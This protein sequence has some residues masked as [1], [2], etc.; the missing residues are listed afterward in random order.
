M[1]DNWSGEKVV[2]VRLTPPC[3]WVSYVGAVTS[4]LQARGIKCDFT[5]VAGMSGYAFVVNVDPEL[6]PTGPVAFDWEM[7]IEGTQALGI[8]VEL[9]AVERNADDK[10]LEIELFERVRSEIDAG[11]CCVVWGAGEAPEFVIVYGYR[12]DSYLVRSSRSCRVWDEERALG[13]EEE[14][15]ESVRYDNLKAPWRLAAFFFGERIKPDVEL[16]ERQAIS[17]GVKLLRGQHACFDSGYFYGASAFRSWSDILERKHADPVGNA[18]NL[19]C[20][21]ELQM[22]AAG[23]CYRLA[24]KRERAAKALIETATFF[25]CSRQNLEILKEKL[26]RQVERGFDEWITASNAI[27]LLKECSSLNEQAAAGLERALG[28]M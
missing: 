8:E 3:S 18:F 2:D 24:K 7:L 11:R 22:F 27:R 5:D 4:V 9:V 28:L 1:S 15:E 16:Q 6:L 23:F 10:E 14:T 25:Q 21:W 13:P 20:Y 26:P 12:G 17:R 19:M